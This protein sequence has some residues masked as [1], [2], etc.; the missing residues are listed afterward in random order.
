[1][2]EM[3]AL[4]PDIMISLDS[5]GIV[6]NAILA[7]GI[8]TENPADWV[9]SRWTDTV[10]TDEVPQIRSMF[11]TARISGVSAFGQV[12]QRLPSGV[13]IPVEYTIVKI[14]S[15]KGYVAIG[16]SVEAIAELQL[17]L[18]EAQRALEH[19]YWKLRD[20]E[21]RYRLLFDA[22]DEAFVV[23]DSLDLRVLEANPAAIEAFGLSPVGR[24]ITKEVALE[25]REAFGD[26]LG[27]V[28][29][30]GKAPRLG[31]GLSRSDSRWFVR[32]ALMSS[33][34]PQV[35][36]LQMAPATN[37]PTTIAPTDPI[38]DAFKKI[39]DGAVLL[40]AKGIVQ[41][42]NAAFLDLA[43]VASEEQIIGR[44]VSGWLDRPGADFGVL[45]SQVKRHD[46]VRRFPTMLRGDL[47]TEAEVELSAAGIGGETLE[48]VLILA[49]DTN[50]HATMLEP[51]AGNNKTAVLFPLVEEI[52]KRTLPQL[53]DEAVGVL[54]AF[55]IKSA[56]EIAGQN[57]TEA[58]KLLG[59]SRQSLYSKM[60]RYAE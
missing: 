16:K 55:C 8:S 20:V 1:M 3:T 50:Q 5:S 28:R 51:I 23:V 45:M 59:L 26:M 39:P 44:H 14:G 22:S 35:Y 38:Y 41:R 57:R 31:I 46:S 11:E 60:N 17:R 52:G 43:Q 18:V 27:R 49:R 48:Q 36:L 40:D 33:E 54:E 24:E 37:G 56:L 15:P 12:R 34:A 4:R 42:A 21:T 29:S 13:E 9:G 7:N 10:D 32:A 53:V 6:T 30:E 47:G 2:T 25:D 19:D 58:A